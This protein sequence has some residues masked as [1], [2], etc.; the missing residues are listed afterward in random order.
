M[1]PGLAKSLLSLFRGTADENEEQ[2]APSI[3]QSRCTSVV[4]NETASYH[5]SMLDAVR[6]KYYVSKVLGTGQFSVVFQVRDRRFELLQAMKVY[7]KGSTGCGIEMTS[8][9]VRREIRALKTL[10][11]PNILDLNFVKEDDTFIY[12]ATECCE[13]GSLWRVVSASPAQLDEHYALV[14]FRQLLTAVE[15]IHG[16]G[17]SHRDITPDNVLMNKWECVFLADFSLA[18]WRNV[19]GEFVSSR[20]C[21]TA[22][23]AAPE[24]LPVSPDDRTGQYCPPLAD[25]WSC[26]TLRY[27][28][29]TSKEPPIWCEA[30]EHLLC[31]SQGN[32]SHGPLRVTQRRLSCMISAERALMFTSRPT[33]ALLRALMRVDPSKRVT[34]VTAIVMCDEAMEALTK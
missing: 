28:L 27:T 19:D 25:I 33:L 22:A 18:V 9:L 20:P 8:L 29:L 3:Q 17:V 7:R 32:R 14:L 15:F 21:G 1:L 5:I 12:I 26:G 4:D 6:E 24:V 23:Y 31:T 30:T 16:R 2:N 13:R 10:C 11:H 34:A